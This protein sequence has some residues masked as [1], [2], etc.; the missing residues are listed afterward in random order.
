MTYVR[1]AQV[2]SPLRQ[3]TVV[4][5]DDNLVGLYFPE[6][7]Y[8][9]KES[10]VGQRVDV[11][12]DET[13]STVENQLQEFLDGNRQ[14]FHVPVRPHGDD[15]SQQVWSLLRGI[16]YGE[17]TSYGQL[18]ERLGNKRL[19]QRVGQAVGHNPVSIVI[20]CHRVL[21]ADGSLTGYA[22][23]LDRKRYLLELEEPAAADSGRLF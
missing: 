12:T 15:F 14:E 3:L 20:P 16:P 4:A 11:E 18:A 1:H 9:P 10:D 17:T 5:E 2:E 7:R 13:L 6:H 8:P 19:A 21:G 22:G 23:G